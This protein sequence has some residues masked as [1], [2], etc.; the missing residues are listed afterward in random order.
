MLLTGRMAPN[1]KTILDFR[2]E[3]DE[4]ARLVNREFVM[5]CRKIGLTAIYQPASSQGIALFWLD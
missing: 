5:L 2:E 4:A 3:H 1:F